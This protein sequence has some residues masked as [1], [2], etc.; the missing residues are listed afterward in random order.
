[1]HVAVEGDGQEP[2]V[3][4]LAAA[5]AGPVPGQVA[6]AL[7]YA[8][9]EALVNVATHA[10]TGRAWV[11]VGP[12]GTAGSGGVRVTVRD[13]GIGFDPAAVDPGRLGLRR[14]ITERVADL[15]GHAAVR[16][17]PGGGTVV[18]LCWPAPA[19]GAPSPGSPR[20]AR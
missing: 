6:M 14:S 15:G 13:A 1:V 2:A 5:R 11:E 3:P 18:D 7:A 10:R 4:A 16:S 8:V 19:A 17:E 9:R 12:S 20:A